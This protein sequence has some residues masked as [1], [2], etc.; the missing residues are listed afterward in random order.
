M[1][2]LAH[3]LPRA[4]LSLAIDAKNHHVGDT[5]QQWTDLPWLFSAEISTMLKPGTAPSTESCW[6]AWLLSAISD[7][8]WRAAGSSFC[9]TTN[10]WDLCAA[11]AVWPLVHTTEVSPGLR[12]EYTSKIHHIAGS[13]NVLADSLSRLL[14]VAA[15]PPAVAAEVPPASTGPISWVEI[16][17]SQAM[18]SQ[19]PALLSS[20]SLQ[21]QW[22]T[23]RAAEVW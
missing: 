9:L 8:W 23:F 4:E 7:F 17:V 6:P 19:L 12:S 3:P 21:L 1:A 5:L 10:R 13:E 18:C 22:I 20:T 14:G 16:T 2:V 15:Q 11:H